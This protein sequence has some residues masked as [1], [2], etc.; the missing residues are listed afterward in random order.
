MKFLR[1]LDRYALFCLLLLV[2]GLSF[3]AYFRHWIKSDDLVPLAM[4][5]VTATLAAITWQYVR[6]TQKQL[7]LFREQWNYHQQIGLEFGIKKAHGKPWLR[8]ANTGGV[9]VL[10]SKTVFRRRGK[11]PFTRISVRMIGEGQNYGFYVPSAVY[12]DEPHNC[13]INVTLHYKGYGK[14]EQTISRAFRIEL[15][16]GNV[17]HIRR[18]IHEW[19]S[20]PCPKCGAKLIMMNT[21]NLEN[22][23]E[24]YKREAIMK[25]QLRVTCPQHQSPWMDTVE[26]I[27][28]RN[29]RE[30]D[31]GT[32]A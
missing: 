18:G 30:K 31:N 17:Y 3:A 6:T 7:D 1:F 25:D 22:Y 5:A 27:N 9:R 24:A 10:L 8:I 19:W 28:E 14:S 16:S 2:I 21:D 20:V 11:K 29:K 12:K 23:D 26:T 15:L 32:E 4:L 13:D